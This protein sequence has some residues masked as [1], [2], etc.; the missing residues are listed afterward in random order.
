MYIMQILLQTWNSKNE[1]Y[2]LYITVWV[3]SDQDTSITYTCNIQ[4]TNN[5]ILLQ[6][7]QLLQVYTFV[8]SIEVVI[9]NK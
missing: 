2:L 6:H 3:P 1:L 5:T 9:K 4:S 8:C 7:G